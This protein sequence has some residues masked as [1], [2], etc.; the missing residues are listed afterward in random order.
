M[1]MFAVGKSYENI[2]WFSGGVSRYKVVS[3]TEKTVT[4][5]RES[6]ELDGD[7]ITEE[8]YDIKVD[9]NG[10]KYVLFYSYHGVENRMYAGKF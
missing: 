3:R 7:H 1:E 8:T 5:V 6:H 4:F 10:N 2:C 9:E